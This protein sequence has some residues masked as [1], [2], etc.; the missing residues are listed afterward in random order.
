MKA[1][2]LRHSG[3]DET[4]AQVQFVRRH[5]LQFGDGREFAAWVDRRCPKLCAVYS[6]ETGRV[7]IYARL[8]PA[9]ALDKGVPV[10][11]GALAVWDESPR[12]SVEPGRRLYLNGKLVCSLLSYPER[13][14]AYSPGNVDRLA[15]KLVEL[16]NANR[17]EL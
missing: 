15:H 7:S 3:D 13:P 5:S 10:Q 4:D 17:V 14:A 9:N 6:G 16:L 8:F 12:W 1:Q 2:I 11:D